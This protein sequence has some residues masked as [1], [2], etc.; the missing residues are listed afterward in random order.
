MYHIQLIFLRL[1]ILCNLWTGSPDKVVSYI[2]R[3]AR[4]QQATECIA[5]VLLT[6]LL[7]YTRTYCWDRSIQ[8]IA[9]NPNKI[10]FTSYFCPGVFPVRGITNT[11]AVYFSH[12][13]ICSSS[14]VEEQQYQGITG[15]GT[16]FVNPFLAR[17]AI[18]NSTTGYFRTKSRCSRQ[19]QPW[20]QI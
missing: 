7:S 5:H 9:D 16:S 11:A 20:H 15:C 12:W 2:L 10:S 13:P 4:K 14:Y 8:C 18:T 17:I 1:W 3:Q 6:H 19:M